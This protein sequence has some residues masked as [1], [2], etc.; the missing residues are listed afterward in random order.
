MMLKTL[1]VRNRRGG[2]F[3]FVR[4]FFACVYVP[5]CVC[6]CVRESE[7]VCERECVFV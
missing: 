6:I 3:E 1:Q 2:S 5:D 4:P 7:S